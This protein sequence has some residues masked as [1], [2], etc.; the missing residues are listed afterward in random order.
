MKIMII[1]KNLNGGGAERVASNLASS[2]SEF[3]H[4]TLVVINAKNSIYETKAEM[5]DLGMPADKGRLK[6]L[7]HLKVIRKVKKLKKKLGITHSI[8]FMAESDL[9]N[10][11][12]K[13]SDKTI[14]SVRNKRSSGNSG[15]LLF[16]KNRWVFQKADA[17]VSLSQMVGYDLTKAFGIDGNKITTIYNP[18]YID[19][20]SS[21]LTEDVLTQEE[22]DL[23]QKYKGKI[24]ITAGRLDSQKGQWHLIRAFSQVV[25]QCPGAKLV[26]LGKGN[27]KEYLEQLISELGLKDSVFLL[28]QK[29][30]PYVYMACADLFA[31]SSIYEGLGNILIECMACGLPVISADCPFGPKELLAPELDLFSSVEK[32]TYGSFGVLVPPMDGRKYAADEPLAKC[33][34]NLA[35]AICQM[36]DNPEKLAYFKNKI[37]QRGRDFSPREITRQWI[38]LL[39]QM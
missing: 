21:K 5:I 20:I 15:K 35:E 24:V 4:T 7:W 16:W 27:E 3:C 25:K 38:E 17:I 33:E 23:F 28:G 12:S 31:F 26:V 13:G 6:I 30:N 22:K 8:S 32:C 1:V 37:I 9:A 34:I 18:C 11:I 36:L 19:I 2:L 39:R 14:V 10:V 29:S